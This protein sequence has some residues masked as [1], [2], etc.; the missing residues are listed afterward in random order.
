M[1]LEEKLNVE[2]YLVEHGMLLSKEDREYECY[3]KVYDKQ[4]SFYDLYQEYDCY[5]L[6]TIKQNALLYLENTTEKNLYYII[7]EQGKLKN[8]YISK[9]ITEETEW[10]EIKQD[11]NDCWEQPD[12]SVESIVWSVYKDE[13]GIIHENFIKKS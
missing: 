2:V 7:T 12:Y 8:Y 4:H 3:S 6:E 1:T 13:N 5:E 11:L 10:G 9:D